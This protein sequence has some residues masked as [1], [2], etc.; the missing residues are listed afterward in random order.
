MRDNA[1]IDNVVSGI[2]FAVGAA[3]RK[4]GIEGHVS[5][6]EAGIRELDKQ[7]SGQPANP[8]FKITKKKKG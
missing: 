7:R 5:K 8:L 6:R 4:A 3:F 2:R 1:V